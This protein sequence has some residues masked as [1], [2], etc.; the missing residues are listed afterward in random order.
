MNDLPVSTV[1]TAILEKYDEGTGKGGLT[2]PVQDHLY[3]FSLVCD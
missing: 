2:D 1:L 3:K